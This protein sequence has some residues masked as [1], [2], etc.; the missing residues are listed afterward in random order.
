MSGR[1]PVE[2]P[3]FDQIEGCERGGEREPGERGQ[4]EPD[5]DREEEVRVVRLLAGGGAAADPR[6]DEEPDRERHDGEPDEAVARLAAPDQIGAHGEPDEEVERAGPRRP[7]EAVDAARLIDEEPR[8]G[9]PAD[10]DAPRREPRVPRRG[11]GDR[12][13]AVAEQRRPE[14]ELSHR[15]PPRPLRARAGLDDLGDLPLEPLE[16]RGDDQ[17]VGEHPD[18][19]DEVRGGRVLLG[20][21]HA[22][23]SRS[24]RSWLSS[25]FPASSMP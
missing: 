18:E 19:D 8:L 22:R 21:A 4:H 13:L 7:R 23:S 10:P 20:W 3:L 15:S 12:R 11:V 14:E 2:A 25:R 24:S 1:V 9:E 6:G 5:V 17:D 16:L